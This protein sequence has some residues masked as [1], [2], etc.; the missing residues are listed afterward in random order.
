MPV[1][2]FSVGKLRTLF[3]DF[4]MQ[5]Q[6]N[7]GV[8]SRSSSWFS[9]VHLTTGTDNS[10]YGNRI[11]AVYVQRLHYNSSWDT[12]NLLSIDFSLNGLTGLTK[13]FVIPRNTW[14]D[15]QLTQ[16]KASGEYVF[17]YKV[18]NET[19]IVRNNVPANFK[20]VMAYASD[21]FRSAV[22][23]YCGSFKIRH[24]E[25]CTTGNSV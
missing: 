2:G 8:N 16:K 13:N 21:P 7:S 14:I 11:P 3:K 9:V 6:I 20:N 1:R 23:S 24:L 12:H 4:E 17:E 15:I 19:E 22:C 25:I 18:G 5:F 10:H